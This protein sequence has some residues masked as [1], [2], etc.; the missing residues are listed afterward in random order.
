M[1]NYD[2]KCENCGYEFEI[3]Q[4][5]K[6]DKLKKCPECGK[7]KLVRLIGSGGGLI[8]KGSGFYLTDYKNKSAD[9]S[10]PAGSSKESSAESSKDDSAKKPVTG[11]ETSKTETKNPDKKSHE[12]KVTEKKSNEAKVSDKK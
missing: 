5:M 4:S 1:P 10:V 7:N 3:F 12:K 9:T 2:Y 6:D 8:F 11:T